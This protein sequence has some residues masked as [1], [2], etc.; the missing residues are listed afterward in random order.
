MNEFEGI[1][2]RIIKD[3]Q[4]K[5]GNLNNRGVEIKDGDY[6]DFLQSMASG[7]CRICKRPLEVI[8]AEETENS[9]KY[10]F[11]CGHGSSGVI[12]QDT[13]TV[14]DSLKLRKSKS[15][16]K[17]FIYESISGWFPSIR[18]DLSPD[19]VTKIR[20]IDR[21]KNYYKEEVVDIKTGRV[22]RSIEEKLS[23]HYILE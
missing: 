5:L 10:R 15:G 7:K 19:G 12:L 9:Y 4:D 21:E 13:L 11:T 18:K 23:E 3:A 20:V 1:K 16:V 22:I 17:R 8:Y 14:K 6:K 2:E